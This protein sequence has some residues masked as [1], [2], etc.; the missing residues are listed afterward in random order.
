MVK[1][2]FQE[3]LPAG[4]SHQWEAS[5][6]EQDQKPQPDSKEDSEVKFSHSKDSVAECMKTKCFKNCCSQEP[7]TKSDRVLLLMIQM[8]SSLPTSYL[9]ATLE[10]S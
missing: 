2:Q 10:E 1:S 7:N 5:N 8:K 3:E 9:H 6:A 4:A